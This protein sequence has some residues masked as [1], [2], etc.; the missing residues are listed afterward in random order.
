MRCDRN[1]G[2]SVSF[3]QLEGRTLFSVLS[4]TGTAGNDYISLAGSGGTLLQVDVNGVITHY[5]PFDY[6]SVQIDGVGGNDTINIL[7]T[8]LPT[9]VTGR[10]HDTVTVGDTNGVQDITSPVDIT[11]VTFPPSYIDLTVDDSTDAVGRNATISDTSI[12]NLAP[13]AIDYTASNLSSLTVN[14]GVGGNTFTVANTPA[15]F[16]LSNTPTNLNSG[17]GNDHV[18]I[19]G[20][21]GATTLDVQG[22]NGHD[23]V[24]VGS[25]GSVQGILGT[26][27][28]ENTFG[29]NALT[30]DDSADATG[31][32][33]TL[34]DFT[35]AGDSAW[36]SVTGLAPA[37][38]NYEA[39][40]ITGPVTI[41]GGSGGNTFNVNALAGGGSNLTDINS[42]TSD[43]AVN[44]RATDAGTTLNVQGQ[45]GVDAVNVGNGGSVQGI[46]GTVNLENTLSENELTVDDSADATA[47]TVT[48]STFV[49]PS[50]SE[51]NSDPW[52]QIAGLAPGNINYEYPDTGSATIKTG[53]GGA[54][55]N[56]HGTGTNTNLIGAASGAVNV[57]NA[58]SVQGIDGALDI[59]NP[60]SLNS[61][62]IDDSADTTA[63]T[64]ALSSFTP[65]GDTAWES[66]SGLA[67]API[68]YEV[69]DVISATI[70]G[71]SGG[72]TFNVDSL[73]AGIGS[74]FL[75]SGTGID[76]V[77]IRSTD[78]GTTL[79]L[80][81]V[82]GNDSVYVTSAGSVQGIGGTVNIE[83][84]GAFDSLTIDDS[85]DTTARTVTLNSFMPGADSAWE[86]LAGLAPGTINYELADMH[87]ATIDGGSGGNTFNVSY[88]GPEGVINLNSGTGV[89]HVNIAATAA[90]T[91]L[92]LQGQSNADVVSITSAGSV[93][94]ILGTV[95]IENTLSLDTLTID[96]SADVT[97]RTATLSTFTP[98]GDTAWESLAGLAPGTI[99]YELADMNVTSIEGGSAGNTFNVNSLGA[100]G[101]PLNLYTG[102]GADQVNVLATAAGSTLNL[103][104]L[105]GSDT[106]SL[107]NAGS[108]QGILGTINIENDGS[109]DSLTIDDSSDPTGRT[110]TLSTFMPAGDA[111]WGRVSGLAPGIINFEGEDVSSPINIDGGSGG[112]TFNVSGIVNTTHLFSGSGSDHVNILATPAGTTLNLDGLA[113]SD[114]VNVGNAGSVQSIFGTVN[115]E[116]T[117]A[118]D[119]LTIDDS[120]DAT[121]RNA[122][123]SA[124]TPAGDTPFE[125]LT[126]LAP[127]TINLEV[128]DMHAVAIN[129][130][131]GGNT[132]N[133]N[134]IAAGA[135]NNFTLNSNGNDIVNVHSTA[136][137][138]NL[139]LNAKSGSD[140][141]NLDYAFGNPLPHQVNLNG[142]FRI[143]GLHA[144]E[145]L[146]GTT[147]NLNRS[148]VFINYGS[149]GAD[150][151]S[152]IQSYLKTGYSNGA[153]TGSGTAL[154]GAIN[155]APA[156]A[157]PNHNTAI[158]YADWADGQGVN[159]APNTIELTYTLYGD[160]NLDHQVN[161]ADLQILLFNLNRPGAWDQGDF[162]Y[163]AQVNSADLQ[164]LLFT[165]NTSLGNQAAP[166]VGQAA[167]GST[168]LGL[169]AKGA[170]QPV[171]VAAP[172]TTTTPALPAHRRGGKHLRTS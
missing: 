127:G 7:G 38:I 22:Q 71:G 75:N 59:E 148:T 154:T 143:N 145:N 70:N 5:N 116:N 133:I 25:A 137:A 19:Q 31:R 79:S 167:P 132:F 111:I 57:G 52:G 91:T 162:N 11:D 14:G 64:V 122:T 76:T 49:N 36:E 124:F 80:D 159:T 87:S 121:P 105:N 43:D 18:N 13:A 164:N 118:Y 72:N 134:A 61:I 99:N 107:T 3:E 48:L 50:D 65:A 15:G 47:R 9:T 155:S 100:G 21:A 63:R 146:N 78:A 153:W 56:V 6:T 149:P 115:I 53:T 27:N 17:T 88:V 85:A 66:I 46:Q 170:L 112:N 139:T 37:A 95:N 92:N 141:I 93:Q 136:S 163:D 10:G 1:A 84:T 41:N 104:G 160:A 29:F 54:T 34:S 113:G 58:G 172:A 62:T 40:D 86:S 24:N 81:G 98:A 114:T 42:G 4:I 110:A 12:T 101:G 108:V 97:S 142:L 157:N 166:A 83:N 128:A 106:V 90:G 16:N 89:D 129:S 161:S 102:I 119:T 96:D 33:A 23:T 69:G 94:G 45:N 131:T 60:P 74:T 26:V 2:P 32:A 158:G 44:I 77:N 103:Q 168:P 125:S 51:S 35:P 140:T 171:S 67:P 138:V 135:D 30:I 123:L 151:M 144:G 126:G 120:A 130:G 20:T 152:L 169:P 68:S 55:V 109:F 150:P 156:A 39:S 28:T 73:A 165:L 117:N 147:L 8:E 82:N